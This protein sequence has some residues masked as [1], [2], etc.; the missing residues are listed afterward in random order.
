MCGGACSILNVRNHETAGRD[1]N[2]ITGLKYSHFAPT[3]DEKRHSNLAHPSII[4]TTRVV[5][6]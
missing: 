3:A 2:P 5:D 6:R 1:Y 4:S